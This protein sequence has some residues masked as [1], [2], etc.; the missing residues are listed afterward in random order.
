MV[1]LNHVIH[2]SVYKSSR[3]ESSPLEF[4]N[5]KPFQKCSE[6]NKGFWWDCQQYNPSTFA[7]RWSKQE[8]VRKFSISYVQKIS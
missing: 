3:L 5:E 7:P 2:L 4:A 8:E 6:L 1:Q